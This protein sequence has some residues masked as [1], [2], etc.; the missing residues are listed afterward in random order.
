LREK[1]AFRARQGRRRLAMPRRLRLA[2]AFV[3]LALERLMSRPLLSLLLLATLSLIIGLAA[4]IPVFS[5]AVSLRMMQEEIDRRSQIKGLPVFSVRLTAEPTAQRPMGLEEI[6]RSREWL[7]SLM[8]TALRLPITSY[9]VVVESPM[10]RLTPRLDDMGHS[11]AYLASARVITIGNIESVLQITSGDPFGQPGESP[12]I[13]NVWVRRAFAE[14]LALEVGN[15]YELGGLYTAQG[16]GIPVRIA[17]AFDFIGA[18]DAFLERLMEGQYTG[19]LLTS[20]GMF[21]DHVSTE[22][23]TGS[24]FASWYFIFDEGK[25]NLSH[26]EQYI[27]G[28]QFIKREAGRRLPSGTMGIAPME[29]LLRG[30]QRKVALSIILFGF[31]LPVFLFLVFFVSALSVMQARYQEGET[32]VL[33]SR[34]STAWQI[35]G[36][37]GAES[38]ILLTVALPVGIL[39]GMLI[40]QAVGQA[41]GFMTFAARPPLKVSLYAVDWQPLAAVAAIS[42]LARLTATWQRRRS[43]VISHERA[44]SRQRTWVTATRYVYL[45]F[46][47]LVTFYA[48]QQLQQRGT[49]G[50]SSIDAFDPRH[51]PLLILSPALFLFTAPILAVELFSVVSAGLGLVGRLLPHLPSYLALS[52]LGRDNSHYRMPTRILVLSLAMG[53]FYASMAKSADIWLLDSRRYAYGAD[54]TFMTG[55]APGGSALGETPSQTA[56]PFVPTDTYREI[57]GVQEAARVAEFEASLHGQR[58]VPDIRLLAID[59]VD[60]PRVAYFRSDYASQSLGELMNRLAAKPNGVL[61]PS[62][63]AEQLTLNR[64]DL[65]RININLSKQSLV[66]FDFEVAGTFDYFPTMYP[67][68]APVLITNASYLELNT[69]NVLPHSMWLKLEPEADSEAIMLAVFRLRAQ[70]GEV[71]DLTALLKTEQGRL[72]RTGIFGLLSVCFVTGAILAVADLFVHSTLMLRERS[73]SYAVLRA[74]GLERKQMLASLMVEGIAVLS[75]GLLAGVVC[76]VL[77]AQLFVPYFTLGGT[78]GRPIPPFQPFID[79]TRTVWIAVVMGLAL[80]AT[81]GIAMVRLAR[82]RLFETLRMGDAT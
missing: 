73:V 56:I 29:E 17:G 28:L 32:A 25:V 64:G 72:E 19:D 24:A 53:I 31:S 23:E 3:A 76:G 77:C 12:E 22:I 68:K 78:P 67:D 75:Y 10:Y 4:S 26:A 82:T 8:E 37:A 1:A 58:D 60:F 80:A 21:R 15:V 57:S 34:G 18:E 74:L 38:V 79:G 52:N 59:R 65:V 6:E 49:M 62:T 69:S 48:Y 81:E 14:E 54:L 16:Q 63:L 43:T 13:L 36:L 66:Q 42:L 46:L 5:G 35:L 70:P 44:R 27:A 51:D 33:V 7:G 39:S 45:G 41:T 50:L 11:S 47:A 2:G 9:S 71:R 30:Q 20:A 40:A 55:M 61:L